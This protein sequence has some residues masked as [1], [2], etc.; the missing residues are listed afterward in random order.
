M[1]DGN[2]LRTLRKEQQLTMKD[3]GAKFNLAESTISGYENGTRKP[4]LD[5]VD[6]LATFFDVSTDYLIG[7]TDYPKLLKLPA[8]KDVHEQQTAFEEFIKNTEHGIFFRDYLSAPKERR[9]E[10]RQIF[11]IL[12]KKEKNY[13]SD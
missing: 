3:F 10:A 9:E 8:G 5:T 2:R 13:N 6:K 4:D 1:F 7:R 12:L 11:R